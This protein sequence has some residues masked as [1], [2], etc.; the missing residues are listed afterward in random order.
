MDDLS[1]SVSTLSRGGTA[2]SKENSTYAPRH[3]PSLKEMW[4]S[5]A[6]AGEGEGSHLHAI[7]M[8]KAHADRRLPRE[9][10]EAYER[11]MV[12]RIDR[13]QAENNVPIVPMPIC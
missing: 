7:V 13:R 11:E 2:A 3:I 6:A 10:C 9:L 4:E 12:E 1:G 5:S 8:R